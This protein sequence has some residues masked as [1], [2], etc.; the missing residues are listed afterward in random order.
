MVTSAFDGTIYAWDLNSPTENNVLFDKVFVMNGLMRSKLTPDGSKMVI[1]TTSGY[2][3]IIHDLNLMSLSNDMRTFRVSLCFFIIFL[4]FKF[5]YLFLF[6]IFSH[7]VLLLTEIL[8]F[9]QPNLYRLMQVTEQT[10]P[11]ATM[12]NYLFTLSRGRNR[13]EYIDDFP[14]EAEVISSL[15]IHPMGWCALSRNVNAE[16]NEEV[17]F[18]ESI[19]NNLKN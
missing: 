19:K 6:V 1:C 11:V 12:F 10:F 4:F 8:I 3:I 15:Q 2:M 18:F 17:G 5:I 14:N 16:E 7:F 9:L 13:L